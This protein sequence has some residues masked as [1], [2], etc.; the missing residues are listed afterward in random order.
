VIATV[1]AHITALTLSG[2][3]DG[4]QTSCTLSG[5]KKAINEC[6]SGR[7]MGCYCIEYANTYTP[8]QAKLSWQVATRYG[9]YTDSTAFGPGH[10]I[11]FDACATNPSANWEVGRIEFAGSTAGVTPSNCRYISIPAPAEG[12]YPAKLTVWGVRGEVSVATAS[13]TAR[14]HLILTMGDSYFSGEGNPDRNLAWDNIT[15]DFFVN[16]ICHTSHI[17]GPEFFASALEQGSSKSSVTFRNYACSGATVLYGLYGSQPRGPLPDQLQPPQLQRMQSDLCINGDCALYGAK[18]PVDALLISIGG[19]DLGFGDVIRNSIQE[20][21]YDDYDPAHTDLPGRY[22]ILAAELERRFPNS[23][24]E[25]FLVG[26][27]LPTRN[28]SVFCEMYN[29]TWGIVS[30][31]ESRMAHERFAL[32]LQLMGRDAAARHGWRFVAGASTESIG[33]GMCSPVSWF[34]TNDM[35]IGRQGADALGLQQFGVGFSSGF[36]HPLKEGHDAYASWIADAYNTSLGG[37]SAVVRDD[38]LQTAACDSANV[39]CSSGTLLN[40]RGMLGPEAGAPNN[41]GGTCPDGIWG[42][43]HVDESVD[44]ITV[45]S[46]D[47]LPLAPGKQARISVNVWAYSEYN[48]DRLDLYYASNFFTAPSGPTQNWWNM[49]APGWQYLGTFTP[50]GPGA[51]TM[52]ATYT[53]PAG[54]LQAVRAR[55]RFVGGTAA[56]P[57]NSN[58]PAYDDIDDLVFPVKVN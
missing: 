20:A 22:D 35:A 17:N 39:R 18:E 16:D 43:Y 11:M 28:G 30:A 29:G 23:I 4:A 2:C 26:Y 15:A 19:N 50:A 44:A 45:E 47:G 14:D 3:L 6:I 13:V 49:L 38:A 12:T 42:T 31:D 51:Q 5:C 33:H 54:H 27:P 8:V 37:A 55:F 34:L 25:V 10:R 53:I 58:N 21:Y 36:L 32:P 57:C 1:L 24:R 7:W 46:V 48:Y 40:G 41:I 52:T 9:S 56:A